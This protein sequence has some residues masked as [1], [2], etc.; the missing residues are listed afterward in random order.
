MSRARSRVFLAVGVM[1]IGATVLA[2]GSSP[3]TPSPSP[4]PTPTPTPSSGVTVT[5]VANSG[6]LISAGGKKVL[7]D[8]LFEGISGVYTV[9]AAV[10]DRLA[11]AISPFDAVDV[12][13]AT[14]SHPD[15]FAA[16]SVT[17]C[18]QS[19]PQASFI[20]PPDAA[21]QVTGFTGR[22][23]SVDAAEGQRT[24]LEV[25]GVRIQAMRISHGIPTG[26]PGVVNLGYLVTI[27]SVK[28]LHVG[29]ADPGTVPVSYLQAL[30]LPGEHIDI[31]FI[32]HFTLSTSIPLPF[33]TQGIAPRYVVADHYQF[34]NQ[35]PNLAQIL[36]NFPTAA[37][38]RTEL[39]AWTMP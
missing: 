23:Y 14:H 2:C 17:R 19:N 33:V 1:V 34:T 27:G 9:P 15:H 29:D 3:A 37:V 25:N 8:A 11:N 31:A 26:G 10:Q 32:Q 24:S 4:T 5:Y 38:F 36:R 30:G 22:T 13:L 18:L 39:E 35:P 7:V 16:T 20:A 28:F 21:A 12:A 6:F